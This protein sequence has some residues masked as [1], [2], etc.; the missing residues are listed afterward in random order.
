MSTTTRFWIALGDIHDRIDALERIANMDQAEAVLLSGDL[1][2]IGQ[3]NDALRVLDAFKNK[4]KKIY[5]QIGNMDTVAV[6]RTL[7]EQGINIHGQVVDLGGGVGLA[8]VGYSSPT[9]FG[10]PSEVSEEQLCQ[11][12]HDVLEKANSFARVIL[13]IHNPPQGETVDRLQSGAHVGS[14]GV[15]NL[16]ERYQPDIVITGHIH[17]AAGQE[18]IGRSLVLNPGSFMDG[19]YVR[20]EDTAQ[21]LRATLES[22]A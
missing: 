1:T 6:D 11:W 4:T 5:A 20:I 12:T 9:P 16:I 10:T 13:M 21:G 19:G 15:R 18:Y 7:T 14:P 22:V 3:R 2:N 17:E 8:A